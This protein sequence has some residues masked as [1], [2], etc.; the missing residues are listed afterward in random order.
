MGRS[1]G[2]YKSTSNEEESFRKRSFK[3]SEKSLPCK[4]SRTNPNDHSK[5]TAADLWHQLE[6]KEQQEIVDSLDLDP[7]YHRQE[8]KQGHYHPLFCYLQRMFPQ[9]DNA[10]LHGVL[11]HNEYSIERAVDALLQFGE[12]RQ[13]QEENQQEPSKGLLLSEILCSK[14]DRQASR[15]RKK[16]GGGGGGQQLTNNRNTA[17]VCQKRKTKPKPR[18]QKKQQQLAQPSKEPPH[19]IDIC[20]ITPSET[21]PD[22][23]RW[24]EQPLYMREGCQIDPLVAATSS[25]LLSTSPSHLQNSAPFLCANVSSCDDGDEEEEDAKPCSGHAQQ[26]VVTPTQPEEEEE[27][28]QEQQD[29]EDDPLIVVKIYYD[30]QLREDIRRYHFTLSNLTYDSLLNQINGHLKSILPS[31]N[32]ATTATATTASVSL[33][34]Q[35]QQ[36]F[37]G[38]N[39]YYVDDEHDKVRLCSQEELSEALRIHL[40]HQDQ[41]HLWR[42]PPPPGPPATENSSACGQH[43]TIGKYNNNNNNSIIKNKKKKKKTVIGIVKLFVTG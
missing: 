6:Q 12:E 30:L 43:S 14:Q 37:G 22:T 25:P 7:T 11:S 8:L 16:R 15:R 4:A 33:Q 36:R 40:H 42:P 32:S 38:R 13:G 5:R 18:K 10:V 23:I 1:L 2:D 17:A 39:I 41:D 26:A 31:M 34:Q 20:P 19:S 3:V 27:L 24:S 29:D 35:H 21:N 28:Q 9:Y